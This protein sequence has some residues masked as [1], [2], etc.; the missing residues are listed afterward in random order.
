MTEEEKKKQQ[1]WEKAI[2]V[3][4]VALGFKMKENFAR[5]MDAAGITSIE[6]GLAIMLRDWRIPV[7]V[8]EASNGVVNEW[9]KAMCSAKEETQD[10]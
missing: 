3:H 2:L 4:G 5:V 9:V 6:E 10:V 1:I 7:N 8:F